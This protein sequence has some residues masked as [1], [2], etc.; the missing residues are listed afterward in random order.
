[1]TNY[2]F[3]REAIV[4]IGRPGEPGISLRGLRVEFDITKTIKSGMNK[5]NITINNLSKNT[6]NKINSNDDTLVEIIAGH[7]QASS[8][9][10]I[11]V[12]DVLN[13]IV[14]SRASSIF[15]PAFLP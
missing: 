7:T 1:M 13:V 9:S 4:N 3:N 10:V 11:F 12:G 6:R 14:R 2:F 5:A 15:F 8:S